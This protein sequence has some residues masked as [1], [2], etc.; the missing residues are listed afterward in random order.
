MAQY[1]YLILA[2]LVLGVLGLTVNRAIAGGQTRQVL[3][4]TE[5]LVTTVGNE[6]LDDIGQT[7]F[8]Q[9][10]L[11][12]QGVLPDCGRPTDIET[13]K[14]ASYGAF[15]TNKG[16]RWIE[17]Y[18]G[19]DTTLTRGGFD[20]DVALRVRYVA[21]SKVKTSEDDTLATQSFA[22]EVVAE[23]TNPYFTVG[24]QPLRLTMART[25]TFGCP[26]NP[27]YVPRPGVGETCPPNPCARP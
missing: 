17:S 3:N 27:N 14:L 8:D 12:K 25:F 19:L 5:T 15:V 20:Y 11:E 16:R 7:W 4:E 18:H 24:D 9:Y 26:T 13:Y 10:V 1:I 6:I 21:A 2:L 23:I 22:K